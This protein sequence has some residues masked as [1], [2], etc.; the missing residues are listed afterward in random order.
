MAKKRSPG[1]FL[2]CDF[3][4]KEEDATTLTQNNNQSPIIPNTSLSKQKADI[5]KK[6]F[7]PSSNI[8]AT[9]GSKTKRHYAKVFM[10]PFQKK[11][12][13]MSV[14]H[15]HSLEYKYAKLKGELAEIRAQEDTTK[16]LSQEIAC[17]RDLA[18]MESVELATEIEQLKMNNTKA[19][20]QIDKLKSTI[21][22]METN[23]KLLRLTNKELKDDKEQ[24]KR[25]LELFTDAEKERNYGTYEDIVVSPLKNRLGT[26]QR[27]M[28]ISLPMGM[29]SS[30]KKSSSQVL[31]IGCIHDVDD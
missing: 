31:P 25:T 1:T 6:E 9:L 16:F 4:V 23:M 7:S 17:E 12:R 8:K 11:K 30:R 15:Y 18:K 26:F 24:L 19:K 10:T 13:E 22:T 28:R 21:Q 2:Q 29:R 3:P 20:S 14:M 27:S 5:K